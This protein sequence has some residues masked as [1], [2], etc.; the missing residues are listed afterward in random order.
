[1]LFLSVI[2][3]LFLRLQSREAELAARIQQLLHI[4]L[5]TN[6]EKQKAAAE[7]EAEKIFMEHGIP[8]IASVGDEA[9][10]EFVFL[11]CSFGPPKLQKQVL[12]R[13]RE[14]ASKHEVPADAASYC[15]AHLR[16]EAIKTAAEKHPPTHPAL[17]EQIE[18]LMKA[19]QAVREKNK[20][21]IQKMA[22]AD[23]EHRS[24]LYAIFEKY[25]VPAYRMVDPRAASDFVT[26]V[27]HQSPDFRVKVLPKLKA[28]VEAGQADPRSYAMMFDR[29]RSDMG[30]KQ[31]YGEN[32]V[33]DSNHPKL[34]RGPIEDADN[35][36][37]RRAAI[38]LMRLELYTQLVI[39]M[40]PNLCP[41]A[42]NK[43]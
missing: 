37:R 22:Q 7:A 40:S 10:Y 8:A 16:R 33:C 43:K 25:G 35:V 2:S 9:S 42:P 14:G 36:N 19:D 30:K 17:R 18:E 23:R 13:A 27:Q 12:Q 20:F 31:V 39:E 28:N 11:T 5:T 21:D 15:A 29:S 6:D 32:L 38:G 24:A 41:A 3:L 34:H 26:M 4:V 1:M